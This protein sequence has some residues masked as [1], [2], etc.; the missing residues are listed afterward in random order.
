MRSP[1]IA[2]EQLGEVR[3]TRI[4]KMI[5]PATI[6]EPESSLTKTIASMIKDDSYEAFCMQNRHVLSITAR[7]ILVTRDLQNMKVLPIMHTIPSLTKDSTVEKAAAIMSHYRIRS[8]PVV[9]GGDLVGAVR[10]MD[11]VRLLNQQNLQWISASDILTPNPITIDGV[12]KLSSARK[13]MVSKRIDHLPIIRGGKIS[14]VLTTMHLLHLFKPEERIGKGLRGINT[15]R[16]L[17]SQIR[18]VGSTRIPNCTTSDTLNTVM[19]AMLRANTSCCLLTLWDEL[20]GIIT[21]KDLIGILESKIPGSI[22]LYMVGMPQNLDNA[23]IIKAKFDKIIRNLSKV[24]PEVEE[25]KATIKTVHNPV[26]NRKSYE[27]KVGVYTPYQTYNYTELGWDLSKVFDTIGGKIIR[28]LAK[29][30]KRRW[31]TSIRKIDKR[32]IF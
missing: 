26:G 29:R 24:Y 14:Q 12:E 19:E 18:N 15:E 31:K 32:K 28:N 10:V 30:R 27:V 23:E 4:A 20:H 5:K 13:I 1:Q 9:E 6:I 3:K 7:E 11:L 16:R 8:V 22:P 17:E 25:A 2:Y 21:Y